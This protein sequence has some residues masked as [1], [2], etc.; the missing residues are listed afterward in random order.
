[1][2]KVKKRKR[3]PAIVPPKGAPVNLRPAGAHKGERDMP[4][5]AAER[6]ALHEHDEY[7]PGPED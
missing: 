3:P 2:R 5:A 6:A 4:R 7:D 1:M